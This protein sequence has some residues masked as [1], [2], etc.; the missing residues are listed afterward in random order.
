MV[1]IKVDDR[2]IMNS[3][4]RLARFGQDQRVA[5][6]RISHRMLQAVEENFA[7]Q[8]RPKWTPMTSSTKS[9]RG[10]GAKLLQDTGKL[11]ASIRPFHGTHLAGVGTNKKYGVFQ[12]LGTK[13][14]AIKPKKKKALYFIGAPRPLKEVHHPGLPAR[15][16]LSMTESDKLDIIHIIDSHIRTIAR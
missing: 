7:K 14:Y 4:D 2:E 11:A 15:P 3:M 13:P 12:Q 6:Q 16:F 10:S 5:L 1:T 8:G 9:K